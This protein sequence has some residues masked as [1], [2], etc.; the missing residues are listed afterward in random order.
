MPSSKGITMAAK[1]EAH[2]YSME[3]VRELR[4][5][6]SKL[7]EHQQDQ[8]EI[9]ARLSENILE[10]QRFNENV[11]KM[12]KEL[13]DYNSTQDKVTDENSKFV[14]KATTICGFLVFISPIVMWLFGKFA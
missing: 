1:C 7:T 4:E 6:T 11:S 12:L 2:E 5:T 10:I 9:L 3:M 8:R 14:I 13:K